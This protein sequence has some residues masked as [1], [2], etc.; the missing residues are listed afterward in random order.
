MIVAISVGASL[1]PASRSSERQ[2]TPGDT[3]LVTVDST[4]CSGVKVSGSNV[5]LEAT[6]YALS[7][8]PALTSWNNF[9]LQESSVSV[10]FQGYVYYQFY[11]HRGSK[12]NGSNCISSGSSLQLLIIKGTS[13]FNSW[14]DHPSSSRALRSYTISQTCPSANLNFDFQATADDYYFFV[15]YNSLRSSTSGT[16]DLQFFR[17]QY[18]VN[19]SDVVHSCHYDG[20]VSCSISTKAGATYML[21]VDGGQSGL[22]TSEFSVDCIANG[23]IIA[24]IVLIP[25]LVLALIVGVIIVVACYCRHKY[26]RKVAASTTSASAVDPIVQPAQPETPSAAAVVSV[27]TNA[28]PAYNPSFPAAPPPYSSVAPTYG[29]TGG[30]TPGI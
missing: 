25:L 23:G 16:V 11:L 30:K 4:F 9:T 1:G 24:V 18:T 29:S 19:P 15:Y 5:L 3:R 14:V 22:E 27:T 6:L 10:P 20:V 13:E 2:Y 21:A 7:R 12:V 17:T 26:A 8:P 28:P